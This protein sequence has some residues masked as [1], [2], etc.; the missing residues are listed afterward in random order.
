MDGVDGNTLPSD[1]IY[2]V[3]LA[4]TTGNF[5]AAPNNV[6]NNS[7]TQTPETKLALI[8]PITFTFSNNNITCKQLIILVVKS[9]I[10]LN[11]HEMTDG[12]VGREEELNFTPKPTHNNSHSLTFT[13][14]HSL[15]ARF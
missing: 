15:S 12:S 9:S 13:L 2:I 6:T 4:L 8:P 10:E 14:T 11:D 7:K 5:K 3:P 1:R